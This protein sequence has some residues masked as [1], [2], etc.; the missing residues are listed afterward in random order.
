[1]IQ[2][3][4]NHFHCLKKNT[5]QNF[6]AFSRSLRVPVAPATSNA[7]SF[8]ARTVPESSRL[9]CCSTA[10]CDLDR[11]NVGL[12]NFYPDHPTGSHCYPVVDWRVKMLCAR[13]AELAM[14]D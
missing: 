13:R 1:L 7:F 3:L 6:R 14:E 9:S 5:A 8:S 4:R 10:A 12:P 11:F 2:N